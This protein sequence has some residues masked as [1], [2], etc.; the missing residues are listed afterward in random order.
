VSGERGRK[1]VGAVAR[2]IA[3]ALGLGIVWFV[4]GNGD[5]TVGVA[6]AVA[7]VAA[8][9]TFV[10]AAASAR[11]LIGAIVALLGASVS[12]RPSERIDLPATIT[13]S[14]PDAPGRPRTRAPGRLLAVA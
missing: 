13:Q 2:V 7:V 12:A 14:R 11:I 6:A 1:A 3:V 10:A 9:A 5:A 8:S 4:A